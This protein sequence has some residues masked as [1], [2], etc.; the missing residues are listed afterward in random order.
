ME[1]KELLERDDVKTAIATFTKANAN[2]ADMCGTIAT[3]L[4]EIFPILKEEMQFRFNDMRD[5]TTRWLDQHKYDMY[6]FRYNKKYTTAA[7]FVPVNEMKVQPHDTLT[8]KGRKSDHPEIL[9]FE[10]SRE[11]S[12]ENEAIPEPFKVEVQDSL[13]KDWLRYN[14]VH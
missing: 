12:K 13:F 1:L 11:P 8:F 4:S 7:I 9:V 3:A 5:A 14:M 10:V 2:K 6:E